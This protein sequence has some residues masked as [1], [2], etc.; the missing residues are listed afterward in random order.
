MLRI[1]CASD[2]HIGRRPSRIGGAAGISAATGW[3]DLVERAVGDAVDVVLLAGDVVDQD[4]RFFEAYGPLE[5]GIRRLRDAGIPLVAVAG[6]HDHRTLH[7]VAGAVGHDHLVVLG[8]SGWQRW[9]LRDAAG[10]ARLHVDG[11]S[12]P[13]TT[14]R[15]NPAERYGLLRPDDGAPLVG[16]LHCDL[17]AGPSAYAPVPARTLTALPPAAWVLGHVHAAGLRPT[18]E[19]V[20]LLYAGSLLA[21][22][23]GEPGAHGAWLLEIGDA[24]AP[25]FRQIP[26]SRVRYDAVSVDVGGVDDEAQLRARVAAALGRHLDAVLEAGAGPLEVLCCRLRLTGRT[27]LH[28]RV[29]AVLG[30]VSDLDVASVSS[31]RVVVEPRV[32]NET[33][34]ALDLVALGTGRGAT[35]A[36]ARIV[37]GGPVDA[38]LLQHAA[39]AAAAAAGRGEFGALGIVE[40]SDAAVE[41]IVRRQASRLLDEL[42]RGKASA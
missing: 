9:T 13:D 1:L 41:T 38:E 8:R 35:A 4:N 32:A 6:N 31:I 30:T 36:L 18:P 24:A 11:W 33:E 5:T 40:A 16:L 12:F 34:P 3:L 10:V 25:R 26:L 20:P 21:L 22:D 42:V 39:Q 7:D 2:L 23:P 37:A 14:Y 27:A 17:D 15:G 28:A 29:A 19:D